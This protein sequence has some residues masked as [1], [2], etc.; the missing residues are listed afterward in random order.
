M[1]PG[2]AVYEKCGGA[3]KPDPDLTPELN[4]VVAGWV[5]SSHAAAVAS[6]LRS[7]AHDYED[8]D[9]VQRPFGKLPMIVLSAGGNLV[10]G[11]LGFTAEEAAAL[12]AERNRVQTG[13]ARQS[14]EGVRKDVPGSGHFI[15]IDNPP[16]V[17]DAIAEVV[18]KA[19]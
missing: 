2:S 6:E 11:Q 4:R 15:Q 9:A 13:F 10:A 7:L 18:R 16:A 1:R 14:S 8:L 12:Q 3:P 19:R 5:D 17:I